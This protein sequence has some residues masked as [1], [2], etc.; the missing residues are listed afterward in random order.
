MGAIDQVMREQLAR[1]EWQYADEMKQAGDN[2]K[3]RVAVEGA[4]YDRIAELQK[5]MESRNATFFANLSAGITEYAQ[6]TQDGL[7]MVGEAWR[8][9]ETMM[10][11][12][13]EIAESFREDARRA[14]IW[15]SFA[16]VGTD[17]TGRR[18]ESEGE[19]QK[20]REWDAMLKQREVELASQKWTANQK[21][22]IEQYYQSELYKIEQQYNQ[23]RFD[24]NQR[25]REE[26]KASAMAALQETQDLMAKFSDEARSM[27]EGSQATFQGGLSQLGKDA[28]TGLDYAM[29][30]GIGLIGVME[31]I[32]K[33]SMDMKNAEKNG[34][35]VVAKGVA[36]AVSAAAQAADGIVK[37]ERWKAGIKGAVHSAES[38]GAYA[39][40]NV[41]GGTMHALAAA[42]FFVIAGT[43]NDAPA[44]AAKSEATKRTA[45]SAN[46]V[47]LGRERGISAITQV[48]IQL[49]P[50]TG[51]AT[52]TMLNESARSGRMSGRA[53][54]SRLTRPTAT[55]RTE[56]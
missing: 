1:L 26:Q 29:A 37:N 19:K 49:Q 8:T 17:V 35:S 38:L 53:I 55:S 12:Q 15:D 50:I 39:E 16:T 9:W 7:G 54:D 5:Q 30:S 36:G 18:K 11:R 24:E 43:A 32:D 33:I 56:I 6:A 48:F 22:M 46:T 31:N 4:L 41:L 44:K 40:G 45:L 28:A 23:A 51:E 25:I 10:A 14:P 21:L 2:A 47:A 13:S 3:K 34:V 20:T 27:S 42:K 52:V